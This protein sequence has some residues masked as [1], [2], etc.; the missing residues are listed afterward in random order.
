MFIG[1]LQTLQRDPV[2]SMGRLDEPS[3]RESSGKIGVK[4]KQFVYSVYQS[5]QLLLPFSAIAKFLLEEFK[6]LD[7][8]YL[9]K[10]CTASEERNKTPVVSLSHK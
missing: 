3:S 1:V 2:P 9:T 6:L 7:K 5:I 10:T 4:L 8:C